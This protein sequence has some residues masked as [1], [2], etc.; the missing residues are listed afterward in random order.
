MTLNITNTAIGLLAVLMV[1][2]WISI[3]VLQTQTLI[4]QDQLIR[5]NAEQRKLLRKAS[6]PME[7]EIH[8]VELYTT[9]SP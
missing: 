8:P 9:Q 1:I 2:G 5:Q 3:V 4:R 6:E 7:N